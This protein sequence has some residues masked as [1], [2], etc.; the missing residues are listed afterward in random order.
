MRPW[1]VLISL[2]A[3]LVAVKSCILFSRERG[4]L[5]ERIKTRDHCNGGHSC[6]CVVGG[7]DR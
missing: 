3:Q 4:G 6:G 7:D 2:V 1:N 5:P